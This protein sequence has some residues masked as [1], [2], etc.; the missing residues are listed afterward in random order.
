MLGSEQLAMTD[1]RPFPVD[2]VIEAYKQH[3]D[4]TLLRANLQRTPQERLDAMI[5]MLELV[6]EM[7]RANKARR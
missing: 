2:P 4:I 7:Q 3:V 1:P 6:E 5:S